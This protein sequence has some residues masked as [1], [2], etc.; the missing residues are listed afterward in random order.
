[1][2]FGAWAAK[3]TGDTN[4]SSRTKRIMPQINPLY[5]LNQLSWGLI[6]IVVLLVALTKMI[7]PN[8]LK[9]KIIRKF[10]R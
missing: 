6:I 5:F 4:K 3:R 8:N 1:M 2:L 7:L 10:S 9:L